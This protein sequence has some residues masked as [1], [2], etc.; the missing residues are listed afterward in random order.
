MSTATLSLAGIKTAKP[1]EK[2][3]VEKP[4]LPDPTGQLAKTAEQ[5]IAAA[6]EIDAAK[7]RLDACKGDCNTRIASG[8]SWR[9]GKTRPLDATRG[10]DDVGFRLVRDE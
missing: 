7:G 8:T 4:P 2:Q 6:R 5:A 1:R 3:K 10:Y 9:D